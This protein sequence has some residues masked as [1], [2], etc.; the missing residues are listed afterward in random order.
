MK[1]TSIL[2]LAA[3]ALV[4]TPATAQAPKI[5][6]LAQVWYTQML[7]NNLR[8]NSASTAPNKY[9]NLRSEFTEN[10]FAIRRVELKALL[11]T[12]GVGAKF[13]NTWCIAC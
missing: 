3:L 5:S 11:N 6:G 10:G 12:V 7:D 13:V 4:A 2:G 8:L 1:R 9:Y